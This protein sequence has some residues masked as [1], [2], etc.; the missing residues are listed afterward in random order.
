MGH[1]SLLAS[2]CSKEMIEKMS[3]KVKKREFYRPLAPICI[4]RLYSTIFDDPHPENLTRYMLKTVKV[5][6]EWRAKL[7]AI[8]H[9]DNTARPQSLKKADTSRLY[10]LME[11]YYEETGIPC[12][13][14]TSLNAKGDPIIETPKDLLNFLRKAPLVNYCVFNG[15]YIVTV[16]DK[17][18]I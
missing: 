4:D 1:R 14:N 9:V 11:S 12:L 8:V 18:C 10:H 6:E 3:I 17:E 7:P 15:Q 2:P 16:K 5:R 13:V